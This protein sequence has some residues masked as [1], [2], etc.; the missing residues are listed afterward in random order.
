MLYGVIESDCDMGHKVVAVRKTIAA[1]LNRAMTLRNEYIATV[2]KDMSLTPD[3]TVEQG[4]WRLTGM[5]DPIVYCVLDE[6]GI[7][8]VEFYVFPFPDHD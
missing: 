4:D 8:M 5:A 3:M 6:N 2:P 1:A 7:P